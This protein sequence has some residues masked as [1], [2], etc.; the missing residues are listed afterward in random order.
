MP[1]LIDSEDGLTFGTG[2]QWMTPIGGAGL[3]IETDNPTPGVE[4]VWGED[5][6]LWWGADNYLTWGT[7]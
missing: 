5:N 4:L 2:L 3:D 1:G 7:E 6:Y